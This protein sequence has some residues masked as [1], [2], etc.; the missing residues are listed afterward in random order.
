MS[1]IVFDLDGTL[2]DSAPDICA[3]VNLM[4]ADQNQAPLA[5]RTVISFIGNGLPHLVGLVIKKTGLDMAQHNALT[6]TVLD[7]YTAGNSAKTILYPGVRTVLEALHRDGH[8]LGLCTNKPLAPARDILDHFDLTPLFSSVV[9]GDSLKTRKPDPAPLLATFDALVAGHPGTRTGLY[10][11]DSE[12]DAETAQRAG[13]PFALFSEGYRKTP[14]AD[15]PHDWL[16]SQFS[17]LP[18]IVAGLTDQP[19]GGTG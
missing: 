8:Y 1:A 15:M 11:G 16:F 14:V 7:H 12:V 3:A 13:I 10:V 6:T 18:E 4:L 2:I 19:G 17:A 5:L 9:G